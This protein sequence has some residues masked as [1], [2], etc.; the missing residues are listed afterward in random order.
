MSDQIEVRVR[1]EASG[2]V[3]AVSIEPYATVSMLKQRVSY[4][5]KTH[6][7]QQKL[8]TPELG[9]LDDIK[10]LEEYGIVNG[11]EVMVAVPEKVKEEV[12]N[13]SDDEGLVL[14]ESDAVPPLPEVLE[15]RDLSDAQADEQADWKSK[16]ADAVEDGDLAK[17]LEFQTSALLI[18]PSAMMLTKR[19]EFSLK[20]K[21][22]RGAISDATAA[23][24][25]NPDSSKAFRIRGKALRQL[26]DYDAAL[27][28]LSTAQKIDFDDATEDTLRYVSSRCEKLRKR[29]QQDASA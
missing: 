12:V 23:L 5:F 16:A 27:A 26:G 10:K 9:V 7:K 2:D 20:L 21:R 14:E 1:N 15:A 13:I 11:S 4:M 24:T 29:S 18:S 6:E 25:M 8:S 22:P 17:A 3:I 28:D 19:A